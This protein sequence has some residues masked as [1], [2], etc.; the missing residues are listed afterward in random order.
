MVWSWVTVARGRRRP[1][2]HDG[3]LCHRFEDPIAWSNLADLADDV[4]SAGILEVEGGV[5]GDE[6]R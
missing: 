4:V 3:A 1:S 2:S 6:E 5:V